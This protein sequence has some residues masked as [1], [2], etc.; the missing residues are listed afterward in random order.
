MSTLSEEVKDID[1]KLAALGE[2][3]DEVKAIQQS[4]KQMEA[5]KDIMLAVTQIHMNILTQHVAFSNI[6]YHLLCFGS[7]CCHVLCD[8]YF[9]I[10]FQEKKK[11][12]EKMA[13]EF[14]ESDKELEELYQQF[15]ERNR[16]AVK[17]LNELSS[18]AQR[19]SI[20][21]QRS[22]SKH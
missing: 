17:K 15:Q 21:C 1:D 6:G 16:N 9:A 3:A 10:D 8:F 20:E 4:I 5:Q 13:Q 18:N 22:E 11:A 7:F 19:T 12:Q 2:K 14:T